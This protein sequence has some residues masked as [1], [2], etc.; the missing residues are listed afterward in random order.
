MRYLDTTAEGVRELIDVIWAEIED[1]NKL[2]DDYSVQQ[3]IPLTAKGRAKKAAR[4]IRANSR[5][6][7]VLLESFS[8]FCRA[9]KE[10]HDAAE[11]PDVMEEVKLTVF[12]TNMKGYNIY[13]AAGFYPTDSISP[14]HPMRQCYNKEEFLMLFGGKYDKIAIDNIPFEIAKHDQISA[15]YNKFLLKYQDRFYPLVM[16]C[17]KLQEEITDPDEA[18]IL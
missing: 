3:G 5:P 10:I 1:R 14:Q 8:D 11:G 16:P 13:F 9:E 4:Y 12:F 18:P 6:I 17:G 7:L 2:R 15:V